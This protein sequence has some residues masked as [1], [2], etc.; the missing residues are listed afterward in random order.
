MEVNSHA[1]RKQI[2]VLGTLLFAMGKKCMYT[3]HSPCGNQSV[4]FFIYI[5]AFNL[6]KSACCT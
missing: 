4:S 5:I 1:L 2:N 6:Y 3:K